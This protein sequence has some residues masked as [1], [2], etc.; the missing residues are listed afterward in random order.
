MVFMKKLSVFIP[1][2]VLTYIVF[3][4][5]SSDDVNAGFIVGGMEKKIVVLIINAL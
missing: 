4:I 5:V 1:A 3:F 2:I